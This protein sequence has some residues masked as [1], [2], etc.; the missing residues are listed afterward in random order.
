MKKEISNFNF[1]MALFSDSVLLYFKF[2][3]SNVWD[4]LHKTFKLLL[5]FLY[6]FV[7]MGP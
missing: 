5:L 1:F 6:V 2:C 3:P 4:H 7:H